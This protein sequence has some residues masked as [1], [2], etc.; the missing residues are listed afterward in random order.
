MEACPC[1][2]HFNQEH[3]I[4]RLDFTY[5]SCAMAFPG[6]SAVKNPPAMQEITCSAGDTSSIPG[7]GR[8]S[9]G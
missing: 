9:G 1:S 2:G 8:S 7:L 6:G 4:A 5:L 3:E